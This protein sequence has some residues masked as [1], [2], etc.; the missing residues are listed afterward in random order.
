ML[1]NPCSSDSGF[2]LSLEFFLHERRDGARWAPIFRGDTPHAMLSS[3]ASVGR[4]G[5]SFQLALEK[6]SPNKLL[7]FIEKCAI[8]ISG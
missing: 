8:I 2:E 3:N 1:I 7:F 6:F 4:T 5:S